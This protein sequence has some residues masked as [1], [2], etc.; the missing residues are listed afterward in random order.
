MTPSRVTTNAATSG[1]SISAPSPREFG[2]WASVRHGYRLGTSRIAPLAAILTMFGG[3]LGLSGCGRGGAG[4]SPPLLRWDVNP[5][6]GGEA[7]LA[8]ACSA[9]AGGR[10]RLAVSTL[11]NDA[12]GQREQL[13]RRLAA[14]DSS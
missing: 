4:T 9:A 1:A 13:V 10:Y 5:H 7:E 2:A 6:N 12:S 14:E 11:P 8:A 3:V